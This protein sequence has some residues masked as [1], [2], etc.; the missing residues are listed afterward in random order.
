M[1]SV[2]VYKDKATASAA[3]ATIVA[4][5]V[6][7]KPASVLGLDY[8][9]ELTPIYRT[10]AR[11]TGDGLLDWGC[12]KTFNLFEFVRADVENSIDMQ[13]GNILLDR[14]NLPEESRFLPNASGN[15]WSVVC[16]EYENMILNAGG[17]D[18]VLCAVRPDGSVAYNLGASELA[19]VTHVERTESGRVVTV[20]I[21]TLMSAKKIVVII[22][23]ADK[24]A[25]APM[26]LNGSIVPTVPA[27]YLQ[28]HGNAV[29]IMDEDAADN[30]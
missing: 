14:I 27:S 1:S 3:A 26:A 23:G 6:I 5:S 28:L 7:E 30:I 2:L 12:V 24:A 17:L 15:D 11:M 10:V 16:N 25:I 9:P 8:A 4:A 18:T 13:L 19:P 29:F 21:T 20:G 22:T